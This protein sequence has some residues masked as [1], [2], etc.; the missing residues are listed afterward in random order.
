MLDFN[1][2]ML[3]P[4]ESFGDTIK[5]IFHLFPTLNLIMSTLIFINI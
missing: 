2:Y 5:I 3:D 1:I 4:F